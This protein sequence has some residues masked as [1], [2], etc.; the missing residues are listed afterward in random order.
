MAATPKPAYAWD[1]TEWVPLGA[2]AEGDVGVTDHPALTGRTTP[3]GHPI[4]A[5]TDLQTT[6]DGK[7]DD[8]HT[9]PGL[10]IEAGAGIE[11]SDGDP[12]VITNIDPGSDAVNAHVGNP[13]PHAG[14]YSTDDHLHDGEYSPTGHDH[15]TEYDPAGTAASAV[16]AHVAEQDPHPNYLLPDEVLQGDGI[17]IVQPGDGTI[18]IVNTSKG[19]QPLTMGGLNQ[20]AAQPIPGDSTWTPLTQLTTITENFGGLIPEVP[21]GSFVIPTSGVYVV[22]LSVGFTAAN[23]PGS[24]RACRIMRNGSSLNGSTVRAVAP[25]ATVS[26]QVSADQ[27]WFNAGDVITF[28]VSQDSGSEITTHNGSTRASISLVNGAVTQAVIGVAA[29]QT[30]PYNVTDSVWRGMATETVLIN[31]IGAVVGTTMGEAG[32]TLTADSPEG[33]Y[34][35]VVSAGFASNASGNRRLQVLL[36]GLIANAPL[37]PKMNVYPPGAGIQATLQVAGPVYLKQGDVL[38]PEIYQNTGSGLET[39]APN[40]SV[41]LLFRGLDPAQEAPSIGA[42]EQLPQK[43]R[44]YPTPSQETP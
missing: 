36:N 16:A 5:I 10:N 38:R 15:G 28:E 1:G 27:Y 13:N 18:Q 11:L 41:S 35:L 43:W 31:S 14:I 30:T 8:D 3:D 34:D 22:T 21:D 23:F 42:A 12:N 44:P 4:A 25:T 33:W 7:S 37:I 26:N 17:N 9:H 6:L 19:G 39:S 40:C 29:T 24:Q 20:T 32:I 2:P